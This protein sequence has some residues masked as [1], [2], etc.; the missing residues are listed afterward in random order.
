M[1][2]KAV[3]GGGVGELLDSSEKEIVVVEGGGGNV[4]VGSV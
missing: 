2:G 4:D 3:W 1:G